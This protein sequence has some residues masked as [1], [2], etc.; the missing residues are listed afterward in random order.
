MADD[1]S[2]STRK[3]VSRAGEKLDHALDSFSMDVTGL[4]CADFGCSTGG[5]TDCLLQRGAAGVIAVDTGYGVLDWSLR[6]DDRVEVRER[7]NVLHATP[8]DTL[9]DLV[10]IDVGWTPQAKVLPVAA[11]WIRVGGRVIS[12]IKPHYEHSADTRGR[13]PARL[14]D[15]QAHEAFQQTLAKMPDWGWQVLAHTPSP[16]RG[17]KS[18]KGRKGAGNLEF[19]ALIEPLFED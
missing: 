7:S 19:L 15:E 5:F 14:E 3:W 1:P 18:G 4:R 12:L 9:V 16:L 8:P 6:Q 17:A 13:G 2:P 10:V 11:N